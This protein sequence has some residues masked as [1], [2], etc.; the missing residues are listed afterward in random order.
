MRLIVVGEGFIDDILLPPIISTIAQQYDIHWPVEIERDIS[1][2]IRKGTGFGSVKTAV[3]GL[4]DLLDSD[5]KLFR[6]LAQHVIIVLDRKTE[7]AQKEIKSMIEP[8]PLFFLA[9]AIEEIESWVLADRN[10]VID[11]LGIN[12]KNSPDTI[13]WNSRYK[14]ENDK[15]PKATLDYLV[16]CSHL[17][18]EHWETGAANDFIEKFWRGSYIPS[19]FSP[20]SQWEGIADLEL[21]KTQ[22]PVSFVSFLNYLETIFN[23]G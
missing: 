19:D 10:H 1:T 2:N 5:E 6:K 21:M 12:E 3:K 15:N 16:K 8:Y 4:V 18:F 22:S 17:P 14:A 13:F 9:I 20:W 7:E 11:W 23:R